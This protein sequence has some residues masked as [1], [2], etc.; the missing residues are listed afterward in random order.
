MHQLS[1]RVPE[2]TNESVEAYSDENDLTKSEAIRE[3]LDRGC[4]Y[5]H[6]QS[7]NDRLQRNL[8][9]VLEQREEH[10][11]L[12][13]YA[14]DQRDQEQNA[15]ERRTKPAWTRAWWWLTGEPER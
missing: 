12:V 5:A 8:Q 13:R 14:E 2:D 7:E 3:L 1:A 6:L 9:Q 10:T 15:R 4:E 11:E